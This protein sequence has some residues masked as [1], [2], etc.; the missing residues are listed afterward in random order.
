MGAER[1]LAQPR[2]SCE[3]DSP[4][5][6]VTRLPDRDAV[7]ESA[8]RATDQRL[9]QDREQY[10]RLMFEQSLAG[11]YRTTLEGAIL[12]C[13]DAM[14]R[15]FG[16]ASP[17]DLL[18]RR[19]S[20]LYFTP[21]ERATF[22]G[23]L[24]ES[25]S[26][27]NF[28]RCL[29][30]KDGSVLYILENAVL[31]P[32]EGGEPTLIQG[33]IVD[34]TDHKR[35]E[36]ERAVEAE[37]FRLLAHATRDAVFDVDLLTGVVWRN[38]AYRRAYGAAEIGTIDDSCWLERIHPRDRERVLAVENGLLASTDTNSVCEYRFKT[39]DG[40]YADVVHSAYVTRDE[41]GQPIRMVGS[42][43][44]ITARK[45]TEE[46]LRRSEERF[47]G[48]VENANDIV[49]E[50][51]LDGV[52]SYLSPNVESLLGFRPSELLGEPYALLIHPDD[53][54]ACDAFFRSVISSGEK[55]GDLEY[56]VR[57]KDGSLRWHTSNAS[58][59]KDA[60][61]SVV[62]YLG[63]SRDITE[64]KRTEEALR[65]SEAR[66]RSVFESK[67]IGTLFWDA[68]GEITDANDTFLEMVGYTRD[69]VLSGALRWR[70]MTP[71]E[72]AAQDDEAMRQIRQTGVIA[73]IEKEY[74][75][76]DGSRV[77]I[78]LG[79]AALPASAVSGVA[80]ALDIG[81]RKQAEEDLRR[82]R[83]AWEDIFQAIGHPAVILDPTHRILAANRAVLSLADC[84][85]DE[86]LGKRCYEI[87][88][89]PDA[90][91]PPANCPLEKMRTSGHIETVD[92]EIEAVNGAFLVSCTPLV[93]EHGELEKVIHIATDITDLKQAERALR[94]SEEKFRSLTQASP[95]GVFAT[96]ADGIPTFWND[97]LQQITGRS[98]EE[99]ERN[100]WAQ[101]VHPDDRDWVSQQWASVTREQ[102]DYYAEQRYLDPQGRMVWAAVQAVP[103]RAPDGR[104]VGYVGTVADI[105]EQKRIEEALR[106]E[107]DLA[108]SL[109]ETAQAIVLVLDPEGTIVRFNPFMSELSGYSLA[110]LKGKNWFET[111][112]PLR[113]RERIHSLFEQAVG[114]I[115]TRGNV[116]A[117]VTKD[118]R[119]RL[120]EWYDK[121]LK[122]RAGNVVGVVAVG[123]DITERKEAEKTL[124]Q[125]ERRLVGAQRIARIGHWEWSPGDEHVVC[126]R[127]LLLNV[128]LDPDQ[129]LVPFEQA[130]SMTHPDDL[131]RWQQTLADA[132][133][134][135]EPFTSECRI[136]R[137][138]GDVCWLHT[139][140][141]VI[142]DAGGT[143]VKI[144]GTSQDVTERRT[145][146]EELRKSEQLLN[147]MGSIAR[148]GG[149]EHDLVTGAATWTRGT[150]EIV[151]IESG[152]AIPGPAEHLN[153][154]PPADRAILE[155]AYGRSEETGEPFDLELRCNSAKGRPFWAR[156]IGRPVFENGKCVKMTGTFQDIT[157]RKRAE[158]ALRESEERYRSLV[159]NIDLGI[160]LINRDYEIVMT[161]SNHGATFRRPLCEFVGRKCYTEFEKR[162]AVC[163][164]CPGRR[165]MAT[166]LPAVA[167]RE[168]VRDDGSRFPVRIQAFPLAGANGA[169][170]GFIEVVEDISER[171]LGEQRMELALRGAD[172][173][174]WDWNVLTDEALFND[175][176]TEMLGYSVEEIEPRLSSW[177]SLIH[178]DDKPRVDAILNEHL[179]GKT[180]M[181]ES[182]H[183]LRHKSGRWVWVLDRGRVIE[184][185]SA[186]R[187]V[188][189]CG[190]HLDITDRRQAE[191]KLAESEAILKAA[192]DNS[193]V[194]IVIADAPSGRLR[195]MNDA[196]MCIGPGGNRLHDEAAGIFEC[197]KAWPLLHLDGTPFRRDEVPLVRAVQH[198]ET[199]G[200]EFV[201]RKTDAED[202]IIW[203]KAAPIRNRRGDVVSA[204]V[205]SVD[206]TE[207]KR[208]EEELARHRDRLEELV[209]D[210]T[211]ELRAAQA[212]L[213][214][215][216]R[217]ATLGRLTATVSHEL[218]NP[219]GTVRASLF[220][221]AESVRDKGPDLDDVLDRA[222]RNIVRC[223]AIIEEMLDYVRVKQPVLSATC[224]D[225]WLASVLDE[226]SLPEGIEVRRDMA[227]GV[228]VAIDREKLRRC[229]INL[230]T[231][232]VQ[233]IQEEG[234][235]EGRVTV[236]TR[237]A[238][239]RF[240]FTVTDSGPGIPADHMVKI[241]EPLFSTKGFGVGLG[242]PIVKQLAEVHGGGVDM[243]SKP[244][245][246]TTATLWLPLNPKE[247]A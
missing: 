33:S 71:P 25:G 48:Y 123:H 126:S 145:A 140:A 37:R 231:N 110:E 216:E 235:G 103:M 36:A 97:R 70:D 29:R 132:Q 173:G 200:A 197:V 241:F 176:W 134:T 138:N 217:L 113:D 246:G 5:K 168:G 210:R 23:R 234:D 226:Q 152:D 146:E 111:F 116:N 196:A 109:I 53:L 43:T 80:F 104:P 19:A 77:P 218:R 171:K 3:Q 227:S 137:P 18:S 170:S 205:V 57:H 199:C 163:P 240:E 40:R 38:E 181:Y 247:E 182:E 155:A 106:E 242:L 21:D 39:P 100:G 81:K 143:P 177:Q 215:K 64:R 161:N 42:L 114:D 7:T 154:Y 156:A 203:A 221:I 28:E 159:E 127:Q 158:R 67:M 4:G 90:V 65:Q 172:L 131:A 9:Q 192:M 238:G 175:R 17:E 34:I 51:T 1:E 117:I 95:V 223:D 244:G 236:K 86:I 74:I 55:R 50:L 87:F 41:Q 220:S 243:R 165:A 128:G 157:E 188:R 148:I 180:P 44:D 187:A 239:D 224:M 144:V 101:A 107:R 162:D 183:R 245:E 130:M 136:V 11:V 88:H 193:Q 122:D 75:R 194:G 232:A 92:M 211:A 186:G 118:G 213:L 228:D 149:W 61:G 229:I 233:A 32:G 160:A 72:Y 79:A 99:I 108:E 30:R 76:K 63:I 150:Y 15:M 207:R 22:L 2:S 164:H 24:R 119:E 115:Q 195:Y 121:T 124:R 202:R 147:E 178:P 237:A 58:P 73:P 8:Q 135:G 6:S 142:S 69:E 129:P 35:H 190:T 169:A 198:G 222:E 201:L 85:H 82:A 66:F 89:S 20:D 204:I 225:D 14:A 93:D 120:I 46:A 31:I 219:L 102:A 78:L 174:T 62:S 26:V 16:Y 191:D 45:R 206:V 84:S 68:N 56:R 166:G 112:L 212:E 59:L 91:A 230:V 13:N 167:E 98:F 209:A 96:D 139:E 153:Y 185:D 151:E 83:Q 189:A 49:Y 10:Y 141:E 208:A 94:D 12:D 214:R 125:S 54:Q 52:F 60:T 184:R 133:E 179:N 47:R 105:T 27:T